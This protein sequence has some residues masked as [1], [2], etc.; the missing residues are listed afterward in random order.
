MDVVCSQC[1]RGY[2]V[3]SA[4]GPYRCGRCGS[5]LPRSNGSNGDTSVA[6]GVI[7]GAAFGAAIAGPVGAI[8]GGVLGGVLGR[9]AREAG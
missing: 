2:K 5:F 1:G 8:V 6:V 3:P 7:G 9:N 4:G